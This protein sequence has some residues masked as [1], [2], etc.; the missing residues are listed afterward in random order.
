MNVHFHGFEPGGLAFIDD[1]QAEA[2]ANVEVSADDVLLNITGASIGRV[3]LAPAELV[4][5]RV[6]QHVCIIR[7]EEVLPEF[8][9]RFLASPEMQQFILQEN[10]GL[11]RQALTKGMIEEIGVPL[12]PKAEQRRIVAKLDALTARLARARAELNRVP[13][14]A[15]RLRTS[16]L[17]DA[18]APDERG[19][20][21]MGEL[22]EEVRYGTA[23]KCDYD[24]GDSPVLRI[25]NVQ[26]GRID[27]TDLKSSMFT[28]KELT[29][30]SLRTGD[31]LVIRSNGSLDL[32]GK[33]AV[34]EEEAVGMLY[35]GY[36]IRL[37][38]LLGNVVPRFLHH[39]LS[40]PA[41]R[42]ALTG[43]ARSTS[44]VN[45]VNA[46]QLQALKVPV[47]SLEEQQKIV[48]GIDTAFARADRMEAEAAR[49]R[50]LIDR[51]E[52]AIL[53]RAFRGE[54]VP[55]DPNDEPAS[56]LLDRI[57]AQRAAAPKS[58]RRRRAKKE[59]T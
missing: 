40:S 37:R 39:F 53:G 23:Q 32:V 36:L 47:R 42:T 33:S 7:A 44:G 24:G 8:V 51:L 21:P 22:L 9:Q 59:T 3:C 25:P 10:Y 26:A 54:L 13:V 27:L 45:N 41:A 34:V 15:E 4:G 52:A 16:A 43:A 2:L 48:R 6:N 55:Q 5:A 18:F 56:V 46:Q 38:P 58:K 50:A 57:R 1:T 20:M 17:S 29:K 19:H 49:A 12:P 28:T 14:L 35:A 30:L 11:T 31:V